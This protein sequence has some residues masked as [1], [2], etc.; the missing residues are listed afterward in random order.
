MGDRIA[1]NTDD[2][3]VNRLRKVACLRTNYL[4]K[5]GCNMSNA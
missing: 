1:G 2:I 5:I 4:L 3:N